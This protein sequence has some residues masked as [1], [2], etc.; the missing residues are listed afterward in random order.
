M[1]CSSASVASP[2]QHLEAAAGLNSSF[3]WA[4]VLGQAT[5]WLR[6]HSDIF[7]ELSLIRSIF[8]RASSKDRAE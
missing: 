8:I 3:N 4:E 1:L 6:R 7:G 5:D 2:A